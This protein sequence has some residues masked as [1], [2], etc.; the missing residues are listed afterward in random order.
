MDVIAHYDSLVDENNDPF[1]DSPINSTSLTQL[2]CQSGRRT[3][4]MLLTKQ[5]LFIS[6]PI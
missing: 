2:M 1:Y 5:N 4:L 6:L 3:T